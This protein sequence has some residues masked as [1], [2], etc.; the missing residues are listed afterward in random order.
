MRIAFLGNFQ[1]DYTSETHHVKSLESLGHKVFRLQESKVNASHVLS[2]AKQCDAFIWVHTHGWRT[3]GDMRMVLRQ[4]RQ[5]GIPSLSYHLDLWMGLKRQRD[6]KHD[7][8]WDIEHFFTVDKLMADYLNE[9]TKTKGHYVAAGVFG[10]ECYLPTRYNKENFYTK[11]MFE[12]LR[13][14]GWDRDLIFVGSKG[15]HDEWQYRTL[16][17]DWL[18][19]N[20]PQFELWGGDGKGV[21]RGK[22]LNNLY[23][24]TKIVI[25]DTLCINFNYPDYFSDRIFETTGRG[26]FII[27]P[28]IKGMENYFTEGEHIV[29]YDFNNFGELKEKIDYYLEHDVERERIR[30]AGHEHCKNNHTYKHRWEWILEQI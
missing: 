25:G 20:Y 6:M 10:E 29:C 14:V 8:V 15:Y 28:R 24:T 19:G 17:I 9:T 1:V 12:A 21:I 3:P 16:L 22:E 13:Y 4:L 26:G 11:G 23:A 27:H 5:R 7:V 30:I 18:Q 2:T